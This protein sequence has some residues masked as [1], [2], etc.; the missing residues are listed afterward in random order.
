[1]PVKYDKDLALFLADCCIETHDE[2]KN[3]QIIVSDGYELVEKFIGDS[4]F[5]T[6][7]LFGYI[8]KSNDSVILAFRGT[9]SIP[10]WIADGEF[11]RVKYPYAKAG[12]SHKGFTSIY[13]SSREQIHS[14]LNQVSIDHQLFVTGHSLGAALAIVSIPDLIE[15]SKFKKPIIYSF[16]GPRVGNHDFVSAYNKMIE[17]SVRFVNIHDIVPKV[18]P[19]EFG[20]GHTK[21]EVQLDFQYHSIIKNHSIKNYKSAIASQ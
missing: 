5:H 19:K 6:A 2:F 21:N 3:D 20:Y 13:S 11:E 16:A 8:I 7:E 9:E 12:K 18:P 1:M 17:N 14:A 4:A 10:D 15:N